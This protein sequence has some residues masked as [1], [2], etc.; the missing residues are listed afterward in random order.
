[1]A[2]PPE[3][4][5][6]ACAPYGVSVLWEICKYTEYVEFLFLWTLFWQILCVNCLLL[7]QCLSSEC[8]VS[9]YLLVSFFL[10][11]LFAKKCI[12]DSLNGATNH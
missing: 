2:L 10:C 6:G 3:M 7:L 12:K 4:E 11:F 9:S 5:V 8:F 1:M